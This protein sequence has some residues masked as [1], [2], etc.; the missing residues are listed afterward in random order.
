MQVE[1]LEKAAEVI[2][3]KFYSITILVVKK[4]INLVMCDASVGAHNSAS[5]IVKIPAN[6]RNEKKNQCKFCPFGFLLIKTLFT[7]PYFAFSSRFRPL[8]LSTYPLTVLT[9]LS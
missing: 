8:R 7:N 2:L 4:V 3:Y 9:A 1:L 5:F 6:R